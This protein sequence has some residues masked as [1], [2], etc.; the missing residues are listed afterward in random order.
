V[1]VPALVAAGKPELVL[2]FNRSRE[3]T[4]VGAVDTDLMAIPYNQN[5]WNRFVVIAFAI[6]CILCCMCA[7]INTEYEILSHYL[8]QECY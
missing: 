5:Y 2:C 7:L 4:C 1:P 3:R 8:R 6:V